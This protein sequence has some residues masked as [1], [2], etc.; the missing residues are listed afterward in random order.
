[1]RATFQQSATVCSHLSSFRRIQGG[2]RCNIPAIVGATG[3]PTISPEDQRVLDHFQDTHVRLPTGQY[4]V[5]LPLQ[6]PAPEL[7]ESRQNAIHRFLGN[8]RSLKRH[9]KWE[10]FHYSPRI[11]SNEKVPIGDIFKPPWQT[12]YKPVHGVVKESSSTMPLGAVFD[13]SARTFSGVSFHEQ[14]MTGSILHPHLTAMV[15]RF[16]IHRI[17]VNGDIFKMFRGVVLHAA[18]RDYHRFLLR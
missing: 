17:A 5:I 16:H 14:L 9:G 3:D 12:F 4:Q 11:P 18:E 7:G 6:L 1:M 2:S 10:E 8:E 13:A 15:T